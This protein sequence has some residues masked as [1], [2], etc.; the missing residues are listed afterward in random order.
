MREIHTSDHHA[1]AFGSHRGPWLC[2][3]LQSLD[4]STEVGGSL[5]AGDARTGPKTR[6]KGITEKAYRQHRQY[7]QPLILGLRI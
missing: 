5:P 7:R 1:M 4:G 2:N 6:P 3:L